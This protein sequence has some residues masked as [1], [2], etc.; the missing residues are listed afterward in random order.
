MSP[1]CWRSVRVERATLAVPRWSVSAALL[2]AVMGLAVASCSVMGRGTDEA[3]DR[4]YIRVEPSTSTTDKA[5]RTVTAT[6][7]TLSPDISVKPGHTRSVTSGFVISLKDLNR[8][9]DGAEGEGVATY[10]TDRSGAVS[11]SLRFGDGRMWRFD[12]G[13][14]F[15]ESSPEVVHRAEN[16]WRFRYRSPVAYEAAKLLI[17][18]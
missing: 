11:V 18:K 15:S 13:E 16:I 17:T 10:V 12:V 7:V 2:V 8:H 1:V 6:L 9:V 5:G 4:G 14:M 3:T